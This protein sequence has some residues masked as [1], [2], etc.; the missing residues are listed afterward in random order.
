MADED[1]SVA[2]PAVVLRPR[3]SRMVSGGYESPV[4]DPRPSSIWIGGEPEAGRQ[5]RDEVDQD[6]MNLGLLGPKDGSQFANGEV[7]AE[8][9]ARDGDAAC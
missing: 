7:S 9:C 4:H 6:P 5:A 1:L 8:R 3:G 2:G